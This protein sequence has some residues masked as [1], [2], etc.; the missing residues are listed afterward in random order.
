M[1]FL[2]SCCLVALIKEDRNNKIVET[3]QKLN[4][5]LSL[6]IDGI[7]VIQKPPTAVKDKESD[8]SS[9]G[10]NLSAIKPSKKQEKTTLIQYKAC[11]SPILTLEIINTKSAL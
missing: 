3:P 7:I 2:F 10:F 4:T 5:V 9:L 11:I 6:D 1:F 8:K